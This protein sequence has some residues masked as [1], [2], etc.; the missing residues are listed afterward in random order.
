MSQVL[1]LLTTA[2]LPPSPNRRSW[3]RR[4]V[5]SLVA[6]GL[7]AVVVFSVVV[8]RSLAPVPAV[9]GGGSGTVIVVVSEGDTLSAVAQTLADAGVVQ[10]PE[11]FINVA[12]L[13]PRSAGIQPGAYTLRVGMSPSAALDL[14]LDPN[15]RSGRMTVAEGLRPDA[16]VSLAVNEA[17]VP[18][19]DM[20]S[21]LDYPK[22]IPLPRWAHGRIEGLLFPASYDL[23]PGMTATELVSKMVDRFNQAA[24]Q[25]D[26]KRR[27]AR[28]GYTPWEVL[29]VASLVQA[30]ARPQD[31][32]KVARVAYNRLESGMRLEFDSTVN[33]ALGT[34]TFLITQ[35]MLTVDSPYNTFITDGLPPS[36]I[37]SPGEA[38]IEAAL[39]P[40]VG[41]W[42]YFVTVDP[43]TGRTKF[44]SDYNEF[45]S[46]KK[47]F[48]HRYAAQLAAQA[49]Q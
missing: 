1:P 17:H 12:E 47:E 2:V 8:V 30:E 46:F 34:S 45:L 23:I 3:V 43:D 29:T 24:D 15:S 31:M 27:A 4:V 33:Y 35:D 19:A 49:S 41:D 10:A 7:A 13:D 26:L 21:V 18:A 44:T 36:P 37:N 6:V 39:S 9:T 42:L 16:V 40:D 25:L 11:G 22:D 38:A 32:G 48:K 28:L 14:M 20:E 5:V